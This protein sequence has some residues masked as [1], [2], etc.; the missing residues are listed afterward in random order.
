MSGRWSFM[1]QVSQVDSAA[2]HIPQDSSLA[3]ISARQPPCQHNENDLAKYQGMGYSYEKACAITEETLAVPGA[4]EH[5]EPIAQPFCLYLIALRKQ[6]FF[7][8]WLLLWRRWEMGW[9]CA[10]MKYLKKSQNILW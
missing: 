1:R 10:R 3:H 5:Q 9:L 8:H 6:V 4:S 7:I 2:S